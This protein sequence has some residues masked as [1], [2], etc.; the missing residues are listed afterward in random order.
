MI[1]EPGI[2]LSKT[3]IIRCTFERSGQTGIV[4]NNSTVMCISP[5]LQE[6]SGF[7]PFQ[8]SVFRREAFQT[9]F[10]AGKK[11]NSSLN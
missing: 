8:L 9:Q 10:L 2:A 5:F 11:F 1:I 7:V 3:D 6:T 4:L